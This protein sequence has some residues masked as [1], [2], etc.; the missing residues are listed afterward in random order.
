MK[1]RVPVTVL[2]GFLGSGKTTLLNR[3]LA[4]P[5]G[6]RIAVV[7]NEFG[8]I[9]ID[10]RR[11]AGAEQ[12]VELDNGCLCCA[13]NEDLKQT[14]FD[15]RDRGGF[16]H[17]VLET[18]GLADP[19][20]VAWTFSRPGLDE[21]YRVDALVTVVDAANVERVLDEVPEA[22]LQI[23]R[24]DMLVLNKLDLVPDDGQ[25]ATQAVRRCNER[26]PMIR[27]V[28]GEV[29][30]QA[31]LETGALWDGSNAPAEKHG[32]PT[33]SPSFETY[34]FTTDHVLDDEALEDLLDQLPDNVYRAKGL[35]R[36]DGGPRWT[37][38]N[39]VAGRFEMEPFEPV[40]EP[41]T[42]A[43]VWIGRDLDRADLESRCAALAKQVVD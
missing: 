21:F 19:L 1:V 42:S 7:V 10:G 17:L 22:T 33:H 18:T 15:L 6:L 38:I 3:L 30:T 11:V 16:D 41:G 12:F 14:L 39:A 35:V 40:P 32:H 37:L 26:A 36:T 43:L 8:E 2:S 25:A 13:L 28:R 31:I 4:D 29:P 23:E 9:G 24:A 20:P 5:A 34:T 27:G